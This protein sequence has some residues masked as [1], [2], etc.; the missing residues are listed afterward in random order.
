MGRVLFLP[1]LAYDKPFLRHPLV[2]GTLLTKE[3]QMDKI[4]PQTQIAQILVGK[5]PEDISAVG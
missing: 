5:I 3:I 4:Q 2:P 1:V